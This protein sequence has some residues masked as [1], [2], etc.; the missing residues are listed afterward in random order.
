[1]E[2]PAARPGGLVP[3]SLLLADIDAAETERKR[4]I[5]EIAAATGK[6]RAD[7][8]R[9]AIASRVLEKLT[10]FQKEFDTFR[11]SLEKDASELGLR[12]DELVTIRRVKTV[13]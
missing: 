3:D 11:T 5:D 1:V 8:R 13:I 7:Q 12:A 10:N 6:I 9:H 2:N 4:L